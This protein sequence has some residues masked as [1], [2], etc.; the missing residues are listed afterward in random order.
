ML[1]NDR[2]SPLAQRPVDDVGPGLVAQL[3]DELQQVAV[4][5]AEEDG[6]GRHPAVDDG[7]GHGALDGGGGRVD[8]FDSALA[9][10][11]HQAV[12]VVFAHAEGDVVLGR[13]A[14]DDAVDPE[15]AE[16]PAEL[17][18]TVEEEDAVPAAPAVAEL[19]AE[20]VDVEV[21][22]A[23]DVGHRQVDLVEALVE[24]HGVRPA[25]GHDGAGSGWRPA[26]SNR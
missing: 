21:D 26:S 1:H 12:G 23:V 2:G 15:E 17:A 11:W 25:G 19:E 3:G 8:R 18:A 13:V 9:E 5:V 22:G 24:A 16:H 6:R 4:G 10:E 7:L 14:V 20:L